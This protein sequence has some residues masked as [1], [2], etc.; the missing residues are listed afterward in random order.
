[1]HLHTTLNFL[2]VA[3]SL[4]TT[5]VS[6]ALPEYNPASNDIKSLI[7]IS[8][9][10]SYSLSTTNVREIEGV[11]GEEGG[12]IV[13][14][15]GPIRARGGEGE[16]L[17]GPGGFVL[18]DGSIWA[19]KNVSNIYKADTGDVVLTDDPIWAKREVTPQINTASLFPSLF[20]SRVDKDIA[21]ALSLKKPTQQ[22]A[23]LTPNQQAI[24][25]FTNRPQYIPS[26]LKD[27]H[28]ESSQSSSPNAVGIPEC[29]PNNAGASSSS[30]FL[31]PPRIL[32]L[33]AV[34]LS[35]FTQSVSALSLN[36]NNYKL[37]ALKE[38][39]KRWVVGK[40]KRILGMPDC[41]DI[42]P[43]GFENINETCYLASDTATSLRVPAI[44]S[45]SSSVVQAFVMLI[46]GV[47]VAAML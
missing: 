26:D 8:W 47:A 25:D 12:D 11:D 21:R 18:I 45:I 36:M 41:S 40:E 38:R 44:F 15:D 9:A 24:T 6:R 43:G 35:S 34:I 17:E 46:F 19:K 42:P 10:N 31:S 39:V 23:P 27:K 3:F 1:M 5:A 7:P 33:P 32:K 30:T 22:S 13:L 20:G 28:Q 14:T 2:A 4:T 16:A 29:N 37:G